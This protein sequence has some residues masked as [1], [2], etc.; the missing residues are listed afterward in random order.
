M[1]RPQN[2]RQN[3]YYQIDG[4][5]YNIQELTYEQIRK[6][7]GTGRSIYISGTGRDKKIAYRN[8]YMTDIGNILDADWLEL[9]KC[10]IERENE[11][12]LF[13]C[14]LEWVNDNYR[15]FRT[16][17]ECEQYTLELHVARIFDHEDWVDY[18]EFNK[19]YRPQVLLGDEKGEAP[20]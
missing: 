1:E 11:Q 20:M 14:L 7:F 3:G 16:K 5:R 12:Q 8:G 9:A 19:K 15:W 4:K 2:I 13:A 6:H 10:L 18:K 17:Q